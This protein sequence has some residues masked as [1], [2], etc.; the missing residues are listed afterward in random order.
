MVTT[1]LTQSATF[2]GLFF[3][4]ISVLLSSCGGGSG[5]SST[6]TNS[7]PQLVALID[8]AVDENATEVAT[9]Q[10]TDAERD[11]I[12]YSITGVDAPLLAIGSSSGVLAFQSPVDYEN[13]QDHDSDNIYSV[14]VVASDG[15]LSTSLGIIITVNDVSESLEG[16]NM[17]LMGNSFFKPY[18][19]R[20]GEVALDAGFQ[21]HSDTVI[22]RGGDNGTPNGLWSN[23]D[24]NAEIKQVLDAGNIDILGV[25]GNY[26]PDNPTEGFSEWIDYALQDNPNITVFISIPPFDFPADWGQRAEEEGSENIRQLYEFFVDDYINQTLIDTLRSEF[27][28]T[29]IFSIPTGWATME[30]AEMQ[31]NDDLLDDISLFGAFENSIFTDAKGHQGEIVAYT[32]ALIW[33]RG[34]YGVHLRSNEFDTGFDTDLHSVAEEIMDLHD[35]DYNKY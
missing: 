5:D 12:T 21:N 8:Y 1:K 19:L 3:L 26:N 7:A 18:A 4:I 32:G 27:P 20:I 13:P 35:P 10:A 15:K 30:L 31:Q 29:T 34:L 11:V 33:L 14:N 25:T 17:L 9:F 23:Q 2:N 16:F 24:T 6:P 28:S 22:T